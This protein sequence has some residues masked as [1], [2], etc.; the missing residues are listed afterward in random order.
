MAVYKVNVS[1]PEHLV[2]EIDEAAG[3][4]GLS[5]SGFIAEASSRYVSDVR[6]LTAQERRR[7]DIER[8]I[9]GFRRI[10]ESMPVDYKFDF[11]SQIRAD[12]ERD[13][14]EGWRP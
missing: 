4:L 5:R 12:R 14:P 13:R 2:S 11:T 7:K 3:A 10:R 1:L 8:A 9:E 6:D